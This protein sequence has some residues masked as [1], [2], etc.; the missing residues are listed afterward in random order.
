MTKINMQLRK[1]FTPKQAEQG[2]SFDAPPIPFIPEESLLADME[3]HELTMLIDPNGVGTTKNNDTYKLKAKVFQS[4]ST[5]DLKIY[6][7]GS[8]S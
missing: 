1:D 8:T 5:E 2:G 6:Y 7:S 4:G 3:T